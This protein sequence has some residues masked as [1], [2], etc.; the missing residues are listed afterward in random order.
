MFILARLPRSEPSL[1][2]ATY[3]AF[4]RTKTKAVV[5]PA[6]AKLILLDSW[7]QISMPTSC[8]VTMILM[9]AR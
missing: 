2:V 8:P 7:L 9:I 6:T 4:S 1:V 3:I 5:E